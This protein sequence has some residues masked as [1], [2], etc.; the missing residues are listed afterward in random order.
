[1]GRDTLSAESFM[2]H[3]RLKYWEALSWVMDNNI[4]SKRA[5]EIEKIMVNNG[6]YFIASLHTTAIRIH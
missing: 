4:E 3:L 1:M 2:N 6:S 5:I